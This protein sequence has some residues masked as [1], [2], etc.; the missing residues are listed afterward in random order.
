MKCIHS[1]HEVISSVLSCFKVSGIHDC[2]YIIIVIIIIQASL[3][4][5]W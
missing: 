5:Q 4:A 2:G 3:V 1:E